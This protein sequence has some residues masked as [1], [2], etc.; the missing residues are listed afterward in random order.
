MVNDESAVPLAARLACSFF[1]TRMQSSSSSGQLLVSS[2]GHSSCTLGFFFCTLGVMS[3]SFTGCLVVGD[4]GC[5]FTN[6]GGGIGGLALTAAM[7]LA[8]AA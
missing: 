1:F 4:G 6:D 3:C 7:M 8:A 2:P 5:G